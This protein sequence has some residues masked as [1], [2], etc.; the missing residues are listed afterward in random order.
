[1]ETNRVKRI[2]SEG[3]HALSAYVGTFCDPQIVELAG[4][5]GFD[6][7]FIDMEHTSLDLAVL[8][9]MVVSAERVGITP[10]VRPPGMN[11]PLIL[12]LLD[13]GVMGLEVPHITTADDARAAVKAVRYPP[14]GERGMAGGSRAARFG[15]VPLLEHIEA[16]NAEILL[17]CIIE[18]VEGVRNIDA[19]AAVEGIDMLS[20]GPSDLSRSLGVSGHPDHPDLVAAIERVVSAAKANGVYMGLSIM[21]NA[22]PHSAEELRAMGV[23]N[24][25]VAPHPETHLLN[26][27]KKSL[28]ESRA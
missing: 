3:G 8:Q 14:L 20:V 26:A 5:A 2:M 4:L 1:M 7:V 10:V 23:R 11:E 9:A 19:I 6:G 25:H 17:G 22:F 12:R 24:S 13:I 16:S 18:D 15:T 28:A 27:W 21:H